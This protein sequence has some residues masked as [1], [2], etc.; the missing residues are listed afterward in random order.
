MNRRGLAPILI[1]AIVAVLVALSGAVYVT[2]RRPSVSLPTSPAFSSSQHTTS[3]NTTIT[4]SASSSDT[5]N[6]KTYR[7]EK[8]GFELQYPP[9]WYGTSTN[10][11]SGYLLRTVSDEKIGEY[12][13]MWFRVLV[14]S[15]GKSIPPYYA[16]GDTLKGCKTIAFAGTSAYDCPPPDEEPSLAFNGEVI[17]LMKNSFIYRIDN[18]MYGTPTSAQI[19][20]T[21]KF[22]AHSLDFSLCA[23]KKLSGSFGSEALGYVQI[24]KNS[25]NS[26]ISEIHIESSEGVR[27]Y[28]CQLPKTIGI[29]YAE[30][31]SETGLWGT[32][33]SLI[34]DS[35][36][37]H[38][39]LTMNVANIN[40]GY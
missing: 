37:D 17:L 19:I 38:C 36:I 25:G 24:N 5:S 16:R 8:Y 1:L 10:N 39:T 30:E 28:T 3:T 11:G 29:L 9:D 27:E 40:A 15:H 33:I 26:C 14:D 6:W 18:V 21:F 31:P 32:D 23:P 12:P 35:M 4:S 7:N 22:T 2:F 34:Y 20:S 13:S